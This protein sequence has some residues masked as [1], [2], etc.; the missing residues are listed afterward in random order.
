MRVA[1]AWRNTWGLLVTQEPGGGAGVGELLSIGW[2]GL[3][4][5]W[6]RPRHPRVNGICG[7]EA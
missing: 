7:S 4:P 5:R 1:W 3:S 6:L 2:D